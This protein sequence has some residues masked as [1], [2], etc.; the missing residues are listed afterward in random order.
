MQDHKCL[1]EAYTLYM[2][3]G[4]GVDRIQIQ[5]IRLDKR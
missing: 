1:S 4:G 2:P 3:G 5:L